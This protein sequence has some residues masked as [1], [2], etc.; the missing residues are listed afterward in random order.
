MAC[1]FRWWLKDF[2]RIFGGG[3]F[4]LFTFFTYD[5]FKE[6]LK[7]KFVCFP[8][9]LYVPFFPNSFFVWFY[10]YI[11]TKPGDIIFFNKK[12]RNIRK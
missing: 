11:L 10:G 2:L 8:L 4:F 3:A 1:K 6:L 9:D 5:E 7:K 12:F